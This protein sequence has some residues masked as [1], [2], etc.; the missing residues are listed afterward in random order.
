[1]IIEV[2]YSKSKDDDLGSYPGDESLIE[3]VRKELQG[4]LFRRTDPQR[5]LVD[6]KLGEIVGNGSCVIA[7]Y[8]SGDFEKNKMAEDFEA[9]ADLWP[10]SEHV[11][12]MYDG[13][14]SIAKLDA[15]LG[16]QLMDETKQAGKLNKLQYILE[17]TAELLA[18]PSLEWIEAGLPD[19]IKN[20]LSGYKDSRINVVFV[21]FYEKNADYLMQTAVAHNTGSTAMLDG[22]IVP[23]T[24]GELAVGQ[25][26]TITCKRMIGDGTVYNLRLIS[27]GLEAVPA[28][29]AEPT[30]HFQLQLN[31]S[32]G[33]YAL[34][35]PASNKF[36]SQKHEQKDGRVVTDR[37]PLVGVAPPEADTIYTG[38]SLTRHQ[39]FVYTISMTS[40]NEAN[41]V[42]D[43]LGHM[44][45]VF[46]VRGDIP[47][48]D[49]NWSPPQVGLWDGGRA[50]KQQWW[51]ATLADGIPIPSSDGLRMGRTYQLICRAGH[52]E[53]AITIDGDKDNNFSLLLERASIDNRRQH[54]TL[55]ANTNG[56][57]ISLL[58]A[59]C[60]RYVSLP[61]NPQQGSKAELTE[62]PFGN[63][64]RNGCFRI[65]AHGGG[66]S[67][68]ASSN[69]HLHLEARGRSGQAG[70]EVW[71]WGWNG[72]DNQTFVFRPVEHE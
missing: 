15:F 56:I 18:T 52:E 36:V 38:F 62:D 23:D 8:N 37:Y 45:F 16:S 51:F 50:D 47:V 48:R 13:V 64:G 60:R 41:T 7:L 17:W 30:Q 54:W 43:N 33:G 22:L 67:L 28:D 69:E 55:V 58:N 34:F 70:D 6:Y 19:S 65:F 25:V 46:D 71:F 11:N 39:P 72:R 9:Y 49:H 29:P 5:P 59:A 10:F 26:Y 3:M 63:T 14:Q 32:G 21:D 40:V 61:R 2:S 31:P 1:M 12:D 20:F 44:L 66:N 53:N 35:H 4:L 24:D 42:L 68:R 57:G 27:N